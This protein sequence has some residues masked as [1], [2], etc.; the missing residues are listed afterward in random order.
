M[1]N[2]EVWTSVLEKVG[3]ILRTSDPKGELYRLAT[4]NLA[5]SQMDDD[6]IFIETDLVIRKMIV[7]FKNKELSVLWD[8]FS[9]E[10][11][12][13]DLS[14]TLGEYN[15]NTNNSIDYSIAQ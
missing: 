9:H 12:I 1:K 13:E 7:H 4:R 15:E 2:S 11:F 14:E 3:E 6:T 5:P 8:A 10:Y